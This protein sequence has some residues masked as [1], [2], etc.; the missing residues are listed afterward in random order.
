MSAAASAV[1]KLAASEELAELAELAAAASAVYQSAASA[2]L[3]APTSAVYQSAAPAELA[4]AAS[5]SVSAA[6]YLSLDQNWQNWPQQHQQ[7]QQPQQLHMLQVA[8]PQASDLSLINI[9]DLS[10]CSIG[11]GGGRPSLNNSTLNTPVHMARSPGTS[12]RR[13]LAA[14]LAASADGDSSGSDS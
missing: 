5:A 6:V 11:R 2:A 3:A 4:A 13:S 8:I 10:F 9:Q 7:S 12:A 1:Y 14:C